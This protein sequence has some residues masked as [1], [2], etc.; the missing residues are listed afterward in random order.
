MPEADLE[1]LKR[2]AEGAAEIAMRHWG[3]A[4]RSWEKPDDAGPVSEADLESDA[5]LRETLLAARPDYG[6]L[7]EET[8]DDLARLDARRVFVVDPIDG[9]RNFLRGEKTWAHSLAVVEDGV[10]VAAAVF[11]PAHEKLFTATRDGA[12]LNGSPIGAS[13]RKGLEGADVLGPRIIR[14]PETW[15]GEMPDFHWHFRASL[16]YRL[17]VVAQGRFDAMLT[18]REAWEWDIAAGALIAEAA[19]APITDRRGAALRFNNTRPLLDGV[20]TGAPGVQSE[21]LDRLA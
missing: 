20:V 4:P 2:A 6:W 3:A 18:I 10:P 13:R 8:E 12:F 7:S 9:T 19:G 1:L 11:L 16:A 14:K 15:R 17:C 5:Y 21:I